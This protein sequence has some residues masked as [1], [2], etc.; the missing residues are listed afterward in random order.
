MHRL[1]FFGVATLL[2]V[3]VFAIFLSVFF[4]NQLQ[5]EKYLAPNLEL[6][7]FLIGSAILG[8]LCSW[9]GAFL[10]NRASLYLPVSLAG[11]LTIFETIFGVIFVYIL[12]RHLPPVTES[13]GMAILLIAILYG[14]RQFARK[15][16]FNDQI[17]PH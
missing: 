8:L 5:M 16:S 10:W 3:V 13:I 12:E 2:W 17:K 11:Q 9:V 14:I 1:L 6:A 7:R 4:K 15:K